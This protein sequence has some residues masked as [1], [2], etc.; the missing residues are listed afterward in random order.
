MLKKVFDVV[1][2]D[3]FGNKEIINSF[4]NYSEAQECF[5]KCMKADSEA[6]IN[7]SY[8][9]EEYHKGVPC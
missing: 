2:H 6:Q 1:Y 3:E 4:D 5:M 9:I 7:Q 8:D